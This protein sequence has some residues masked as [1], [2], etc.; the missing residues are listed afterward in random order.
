MPK[1]MDEN[2]K[3]MYNPVQ[4]SSNDIRHVSIETGKARSGGCVSPAP[5]PRGA[6]SFRAGRC[7][8]TAAML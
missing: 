5:L 6:V 4:W 3:N 2:L 7:G 1:R 8:S